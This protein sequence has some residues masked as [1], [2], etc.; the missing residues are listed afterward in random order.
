MEGD[1]TVPLSKVEDAAVVGVCP[2]RLSDVD[3]D[4]DDDDADDDGT[5][6]LLRVD[7][8]DACTECAL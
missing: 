7:A 4:D 2:R 6:F 3:V 5:F 1:L 8:N